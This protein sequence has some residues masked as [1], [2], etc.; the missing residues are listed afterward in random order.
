MQAAVR[1]KSFGGYVAGAWQHVMHG[2]RKHHTL[3]LIAQTLSHYQLVCLQEAD[4]GSL[5]SGRIHQAELLAKMAGFDHWADQRNRNMGWRNVMV[6]SSGNAILSREPLLRVADHRLPGRGRG[7]L[8]AETAQLQILNVH[9]SLGSAA[10]TRQLE[11]LGDVI[12][13]HRQ[14]CSKPFLVA[15]DFNCEPGFSPL[16]N[17][18]E[19]H[20]FVVAPT[21]ASFPSWQPRLHLDLVL[22]CSET[23]ISHAR[24]LPKLC[25]DHLPIA[26]SLS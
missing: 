19:R 21:Q 8:Y 15:G 4:A 25:S 2:P 13:T 7:A 20:G 26:V 22:H 16:Q 9:L 3:Q 18:C 10:R 14:Q 11:F 1:T 5:R 17:L 12:A 6:A 23:T 24:V